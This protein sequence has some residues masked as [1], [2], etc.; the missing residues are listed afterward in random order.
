MAADTGA[1]VLVPPNLQALLAARLDQLEEPERAVLERGAVEGEIFHRGAVQTLSEDG[2]VVP[3]LAA[4]VRK[5]LIRPDRTQLPGDDAFRFRHLLVRDAAYD[6]LSEGRPRRAPR[7]LRRLAGRARGGSRR[8]GRD[9]RLPPRAGSS[10]QGRAWARPTGSL[11]ERAGERLA[12]AGRR[13]LARGDQR[14]GG[15]APRAR[16]RAHAAVV[17]RRAPRDRPGRCAAVASRAAQRSP[18]PPPSE[19]GS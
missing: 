14:G 5:E 2:T 7:A 6:G 9:P 1:D 4:L 16:S 12:A 17:V 8:G 11:A 15:P 3:R 13:A 18:R 10:L 19:R